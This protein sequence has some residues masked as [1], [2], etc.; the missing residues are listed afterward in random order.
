MAQA[1]LLQF[2]A[3]KARTTLMS[4]QYL[5]HQMNTLSKWVCSHEL[6]SACCSCIWYDR[7][8]LTMLLGPMLHAMFKNTHS[9]YLAT[10]VSLSLRS[11]YC[12]V[13]CHELFPIIDR[14]WVSG[15]FANP[16]CI[17]C[18]LLAFFAVMCIIQLEV[19]RHS[20]AILLSFS[21]SCSMMTWGVLYWALFLLRHL[22]TQHTMC[23]SLDM[24]TLMA[25]LPFVLTSRLPYCHHHLQVSV[26][27]A[28]LLI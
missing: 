20:Y 6:L 9:S 22:L 1:S 24:M 2:K 16:A 13:C 12:S 21:R 5:Q 15:V 25:L 19:I 23:Y 17:C 28:F 3:V 27:P 10:D 8:A 7:K 11:Q 4:R 14:W 26:L 18:Y